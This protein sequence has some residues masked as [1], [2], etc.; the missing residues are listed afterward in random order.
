MSKQAHKSNRSFSIS[1]L[2]WPVLWGA[3]ATIGFY[4][5]IRDGHINHPLVIRYFANHPVEYIATTMFFVGLAALFIKLLELLY[6]PSVSGKDILGPIPDQGQ[7]GSDCPEL[8]AAIESQPATIRNS[9]IA[10]RL[11]DSVEYVRRTRSADGIEDQMRTLAENAENR[12]S[13]SYS[14]VRI[15]ISTIPILG[16]LGT[17]IGITR[18]VAELAQLVGDISFEEAINSV[19]SGLSVAFDTTALALALS[20]VLMF[21]MFFVSRWETRMLADIE[22][23]SSETMVGRFLAGQDH[24]PQILAIQKIGEEVVRSTQQLVVR[25]A[26]LWHHSM[27]AAERKWV[28][29]AAQAEKQL[30]TSLT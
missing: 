22:I 24:Q 17:V 1:I 19:V 16:F 8:L 18:A 3:A 15:I 12:S 2:R 14:L 13:N 11:R 28:H 27:E 7:S 30:G 5:A 25:Q 26:E 10:V 9:M 4:V 29:S 23:D 6:Q 21:F 20:I